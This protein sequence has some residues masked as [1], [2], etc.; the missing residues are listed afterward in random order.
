MPTKQA[1]RALGAAQNNWRGNRRINGCSTT[2]LHAKYSRELEEQADG[3]AATVLRLNGMSPALLAEALKKLAASHHDN[4]GMGYVST[5]PDV[6]E[7][8]RHLYEVSGR[9]ESGL[10]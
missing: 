9:A 8:V 2:L 7:R 1:L 5:H 4:A 6:D 3:Y 10:Q